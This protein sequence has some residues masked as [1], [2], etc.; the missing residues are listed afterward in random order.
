MCVRVCVQKG[1]AITRHRDSAI[2]LISAVRV[3]VYARG[4]VLCVRMRVCVYLCV[5]KVPECSPFTLI[6]SVTVIKRFC[7]CFLVCFFF[8]WKTSDGRTDGR[9]DE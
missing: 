1:Y 6:S 5:K 8:F 9:T 2:L 3:G 7:F 4:C